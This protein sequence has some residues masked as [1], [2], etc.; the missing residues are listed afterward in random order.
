MFS[1][2]VFGGT[3]WTQN[4]QIKLTSDDGRLLAYTVDQY[5]SEDLYSVLVLYNSDLELIGFTVDEDTYYY[6]KNIQGDVLC[7]TDA[8]GTPIVNYTYDA[9]GA[10]T[11]SPASQTVPSATVANVAFLNP[12]TYRG[13]FYDYELG[14]Y[15]LQSR[16]YDPETGRFISSDKL[17]YGRNI[18]G[19][20]LYSALYNNP[21]MYRDSSGG[22][23]TMFLNMAAKIYSAGI[24]NSKT[25]S[26]NVLLLNGRNIYL[27]F[28]EMAQ[29]FVYRQ[30]QSEGYS[31]IELEKRINNKE[32]DIVA[33]K[34]G[35]KYLW[36][37][38]PLGGDSPEP[39]LREYTNGTGYRRGKHIPDFQ[40][41]VFNSTKMKITSN[42]SGGIY[43]AFYNSK[44]ER[45]SNSQ[46]YAKFRRTII[47][48][49]AIVGG[50]VVATLLEDV[51]TGGAG[52]W[53]D[54]MVFLEAYSI[55]SPIVFG[56]V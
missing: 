21:V 42:S 5:G 44:R 18:L 22:M 29:I 35:I 54:A 4:K 51:V 49:S 14:L 6:L 1:C 28:H 23:A 8:E 19:Y 17:L 53:D 56:A 36:E 30:L 45:I 9:W 55:M 48:A 40:V 13:Y 12:V 3:I 43:Y 32:A 27:A 33:R 16:Y 20:N 10:M 11:V 26:G 34:N 46:L 2:I 37:I 52:I 39:Q 24:L 25:L 15:Y 38:K 31:Y 7:V 41:N 50:L 47:S